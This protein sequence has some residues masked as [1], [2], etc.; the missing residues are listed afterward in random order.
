[1]K[2]ICFMIVFVCLFLMSCVGA[3]PIK[4]PYTSLEK[5]VNVPGANKDEI[6]DQTKIFIA[7]NFRSAKAVMEYENKEKGTI[8]GNGSIQ[9]PAEDGMAAV[10]LANWRTNFTIRVDIKDEKF[11]CTFSN[12]KVA[13]PASYNPTVGARPAG[14]RPIGF[15]QESVN[16]KNGL[17]KIPDEIALHVTK[18]KTKDNW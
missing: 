7:E 3:Q 9:Y 12:I 8:I 16:I 1:M 10:A 15:E 13:W 6:F 2:R 4:E 18:K 14:E 5:I 11:R 17:L